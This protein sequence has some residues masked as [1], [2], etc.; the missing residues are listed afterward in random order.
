MMKKWLILKKYTHVKARVQKLYPIYDQNQLNSIP[1]LWPKRLKNH[2]LWGRT[3]LYS[4]YKQVPHPP[5]NKDNTRMFSIDEWLLRNQIQAYFLRLSVQKRIQGSV[6]TPR[7]VAKYNMD[8]VVEE[9]EW[10][11]ASVWIVWLTISEAFNILW[12]IQSLWFMSDTDQ[13]FCLF[14]VTMLKSI[15]SHFEISLKSRDRKHQ[16]IEKLAAMTECSCGKS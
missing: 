13:K 5:R 7:Q 14:N 6:S 4:P 1:Y 9:E 12:F 15:C 3:Y 10:F 8:D 16:L 11:T 2:T